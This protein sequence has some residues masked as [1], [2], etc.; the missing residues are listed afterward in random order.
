M[1]PKPPDKK[2][3]K[4]PDRARV[5]RN[6]EENGWLNIGGYRSTQEFSRATGREI[7]SSMYTILSALGLMDTSE[8]H[9]SSIP[10]R[11][12][13]VQCQICDEYEVLGTPTLASV[14]VAAV[15]GDAT[16]PICV[17]NKPAWSA[18]CGHCLCGACMDNMKEKGECFM[19]R[20]KVEDIRRVF[21]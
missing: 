1:D 21:M 8:R 6:R 2:K 12:T 4:R 15:E 9:P 13:V 10:I 16:C 14:D 5:E 17:A 18:K 20:Q 3:R 19:C 7:T 11:T